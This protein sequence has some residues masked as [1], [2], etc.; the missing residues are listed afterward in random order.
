MCYCYLFYLSLLSI[1]ICI[2]MP[3]DDTIRDPNF[4]DMTPD[5]TPST[6][7]GCSGQSKPTFMATKTKFLFSLVL[8]L[9]VIA[10]VLMERFPNSP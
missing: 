6:S 10:F 8:F 5:K 9:E 1:P 4:C 7:N 3:L 2:F